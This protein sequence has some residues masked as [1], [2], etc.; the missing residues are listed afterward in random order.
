MPVNIC[1]IVALLHIGILLV[2]LHLFFCLE[3][4]NKLSRRVM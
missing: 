1:I 4:V 2:L 3:E